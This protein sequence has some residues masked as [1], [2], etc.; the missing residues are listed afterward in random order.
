MST[1]KR[2]QVL[3]R[4]DPAVHD[5]VAKWAADELRSTNAHVE[6]LL[7]RV[8]AEAGRLPRQAGPLPKRGRPSAPSEPAPDPTAPHPVTPDPVAPDPA[9]P[10]DAADVTDT[11]APPTPTKD[12][13]A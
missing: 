10:H 6:F 11:P 5:A 12:D 4:L 9:T 13:D 3:L 1:P 8:L 7:R 2:K